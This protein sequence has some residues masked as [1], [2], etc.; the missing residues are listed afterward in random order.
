MIRRKG[1]ETGESPGSIFV[2]FLLDEPSRRL[3][4]EDHAD[5]E[6]EAPNKL[7][8]DGDLPRSMGGLV[9]GAVV[10]DRGE[11]ETDGDCPLVTGDDGATV[12][13]GGE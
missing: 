8:T 10:D 6:D 12:D 13:R 7:E 1:D 3:G 9:L 11:E 2:A 4:E 5:S